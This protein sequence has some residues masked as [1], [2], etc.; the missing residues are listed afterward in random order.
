MP[1]ERYA[2]ACYRYVELNPVEAQMVQHARQYQWSSH[3]TNV[4]SLHGSWVVP[5]PAYEA[6]ATEPVLRAQAYSALCDVAVD[7]KIIDEIRKATRRGYAVGATRR[8]RG[9]P[10]PPVM[11]KMGSVPI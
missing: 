3:R 8:P 9:R 2:L 4:G 10:R 1:T 5:H 11:R 6:L 7:P